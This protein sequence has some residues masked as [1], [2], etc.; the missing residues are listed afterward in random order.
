TN[1]SRPITVDLLFDFTVLAR[2]QED[3]LIFT[4]L[5]AATANGTVQAVAAENT[6]YSFQNARTQPGHAQASGGAW[7]Q[8]GDQRD[9][10]PGRSPAAA[11]RSIR[12]PQA[13]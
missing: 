8:R 9:D 10:S 5:A 7:R 2:P 3:G 4:N 12:I 1:P 11:A 6:T 13:V